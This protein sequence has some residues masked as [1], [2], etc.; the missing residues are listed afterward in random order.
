MKRR[1]TYDCNTPYKA[2][3]L[4]FSTCGPNSAYEFEF[5]TDYLTRTHES[6][7]LFSTWITGWSYVQQINKYLNNTIFGNFSN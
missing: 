7:W 2:T 3:N 5:Y 6:L 4:R 1:K